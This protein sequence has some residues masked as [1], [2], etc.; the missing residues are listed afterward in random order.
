M[1]ILET[2]NY[3]YLMGKDRKP[4]KMKIEEYLKMRNDL[5]PLIPEVDRAEFER[6]T[7]NVIK[8]FEAAGDYNAFV[9]S[10]DTSKGS[11]RPPTDITKMTGEEVLAYQARLKESTKA[12]GQGKINGVAYGTSAVGAYQIVR[13][14][15]TNTNKKGYYDENPGERGKL[16]DEEQQ[17]KIYRWL[18]KDAVDKFMVNNDKEAFKTAVIKTW[19]AFK[20]KNSEARKQLDALLDNPI[21][22]ESTTSSEPATKEQRKVR[23]KFIM[24]ELEILSKEALK[25][26]GDYRPMLVGNTDVAKEAVTVVKD[27]AEK[28]KDWLT[29]LIP[30]DSTLGSRAASFFGLNGDQSVG[31]QSNTSSTPQVNII[32]TDNSVKVASQSGGGGG[33]SGPSMTTNSVTNKP[34][35]SYY[36]FMAGGNPAQ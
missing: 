12:A 20:P 35:F 17:D 24:K 13:E 2:E 27:T 10:G 34:Y 5:D 21:F 6:M 7:G 16:F 31:L 22:A 23:E 32:T 26:S 33:G 36:Q 30:D 25:T 1:P 19:E 15:L 29:N 9:F 8:K 14:N 4:K 28:V 11:I 3:V 18:I